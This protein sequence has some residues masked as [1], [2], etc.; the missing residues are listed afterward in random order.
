MAGVGDPDKL[1]PPLEGWGGKRTR[2]MERSV[3]ACVCVC[4][5]SV[6]WR[7]RR[8]GK[9]CC[10]ESRAAAAAAAGW[11]AREREVSAG[12]GGGGAG[13][14]GRGGRRRALHSH[15]ELRAA[16]E[17]RHTPARRA[18]L[19]VGAAGCVRLRRRP[20]PS[21]RAP[22]RSKL[23]W[24]PMGKCRRTRAPSGPG[25]PRERAREIPLSSLSSAAA[26]VPEPGDPRGISEK[27]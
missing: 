6:R 13:G 7:R 1:A 10:A 24:R 11:S 9:G 17:G 16:A 3:R 25:S 2:K 21:H 5:V 15:R 12:P 27:W 4:V 19:S 18:R 22:L 20:G 8:R 23:L 26:S 14:A